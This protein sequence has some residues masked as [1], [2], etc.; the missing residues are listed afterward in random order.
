MEPNLAFDG[1]V[2]KFGRLLQN[3]GNPSY[4]SASALL[5]P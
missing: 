3:G 4:L 1:E 2:V 5:S